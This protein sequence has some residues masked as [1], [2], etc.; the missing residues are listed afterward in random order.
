MIDFDHPSLT[1][2]SGGLDPVGTVFRGPGNWYYRGLSAQSVPWLQMLQQ[3]HVLERLA[4][5]SLIPPQ[6]IDVATGR[7]YC[8][9]LVSRGNAW[10]IHASAYCTHAFRD[11]A[12]VWLRINEILNDIDPTLGLIDGHY[13]NVAAFDQ[14][15]PKWV[16]I[17]SIA[18]LKSTQ[19][20]VAQF[21]RYFIYPLLVFGQMPEKRPAVRR[22]MRH[23]KG[24]ITSDE[25]SS[26]LGSA[27]QLDIHPDMPRLAV[28]K[29]LMDIVNGIDLD[30]HRGFWSD[31]RPSEHLVKAMNGRFLAD[32]PDPRPARIVDLA[33]ELAPETVI[34]VGANDGLFSVLCAKRGMRVLA[35]DTAEFALNK[36]YKL[37]SSAPD[38]D[39]CVASN[40]FL[41][42]E[43]RADLVLALA[44]THHLVLKQK[45]TWDQIAAKLAAMTKRAVIIEYMPDGCGGTRTHPEVQPNPLPAWYSLDHCLTALRRF[46]ADVQTIEYGR[47]VQFSRRVLIICREPSAL[48]QSHSDQ[49]VT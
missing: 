28:L 35:I 48:P 18:R 46:F 20:G 44:L 24:G 45:L 42:V 41:D 37:V 32:F 13:G 21:I 11:A 5:A 25:I 23:P 29:R 14:S 26:Y 2:L 8:T 6:T 39:V 34:D 31:Y 22:R 33:A 12:L 4:Q 3:R 9:A 1:K 49:N 16:D 10:D 7:N 27:P 47:K 43:Q 38:L 40:A 15:R 36:L 30:T 19:Q 17:G